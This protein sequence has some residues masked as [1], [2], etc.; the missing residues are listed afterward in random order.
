VAE[1]LKSESVPHRTPRTRAK[2]FSP[3]EKFGEG[4]DMGGKFCGMCGMIA[5]PSHLHD[6][7]P[8]AEGSK[9]PNPGMP[10]NPFTLKGGK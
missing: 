2:E 9:T 7:Q 6:G 5:P 8:R 3:S 4:N 1:K 10:S